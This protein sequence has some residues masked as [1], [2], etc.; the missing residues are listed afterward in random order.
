MDL[1]K[2][3]SPVLSESEGNKSALNSG[4][5]ELFTVKY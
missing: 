4:L 3:K 1:P 2:I 5:K